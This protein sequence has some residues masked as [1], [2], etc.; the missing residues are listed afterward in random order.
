MKEK[1][2]AW[3]TTFLLHAGE[4]C[5]APMPLRNASPPPDQIPEGLTRSLLVFIEGR[6]LYGSPQA[7]T[8]LCAWPIW[9]STPTGQI[10]VD[11]GTSIADLTAQERLALRDWLINR[12]ADAWSAADPAIRDLLHEASTGSDEP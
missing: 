4:L 9:L 7:Y 6:D 2:M 11:F 1:H 10:W 5:A 12:S 3:T 8:K